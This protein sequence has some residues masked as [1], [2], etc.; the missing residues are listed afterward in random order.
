MHLNKWPQTTEATKMLVKRT[1]KKK[2]KS[3]ILAIS[4]RMHADYYLLFRIL[5]L[6]CIYFD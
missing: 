5:L 6:Y 2:I 1:K 4:A 3:T